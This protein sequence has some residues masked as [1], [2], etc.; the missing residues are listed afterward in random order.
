ME[1][2]RGTRH[3]IPSVAVL[4]LAGNLA[5]KKRVEPGPASFPID[6]PMFVT[7]LIAVILALALGP[8][9]EHMT[10]WARPLQ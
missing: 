6:S 5:K 3:L 9:V 1:H 2:Y 10:M 8:W 4:A 7:L